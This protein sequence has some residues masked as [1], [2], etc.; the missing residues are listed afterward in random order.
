MKPVEESRKP[1]ER[2]QIVD[3]D[4]LSLE[5]PLIEKKRV[6]R[7]APTTKMSYS[8]LRDPI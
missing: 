1:T 8:R 4:I 7:Q 2:E 5:L 3:K 6:A